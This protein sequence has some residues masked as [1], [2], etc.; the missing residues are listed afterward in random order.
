MPADKNFFE[1]SKQQSVIKTAIV[2][3]Y[4][5]A[6]AKVIMPAAKK[7][8]GRIA[9]IDVF[10]GPGRYGDGTK[11]TPLLILEQAIADSDMREMLVTLL[12]DGDPENVASLAAEIAAL[13]DIG[14]LRHQPQITANIVND[15][16]ARRFEERR[17]VPTLLFIDPWGYKGLSLRLIEAVLKDWGCDCIFFFNYNRISMGLPNEVVAPHLDALFG[18]TRADDLRRRLESL[19]GEDRELAIVEELSRALHDKGGRYVLPFRFRN[20]AG[21]LLDHEGDH[22]QPKLDRGSGCS[23][24]RVQSGG[25]TVP[26]ALRALAA[27]RP[28]RRTPSRGVPRADA[29]NEG[30]LREASYG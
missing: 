21:S 11:S 10:A 19:S 8:G 7:G 1:E 9:Y 15:D 12:N 16:L 6:W 4:F 3:K 25:R 14:K 18:K 20:E 5:W 2:S 23:L 30:G 27:S 29:G 28:A 26:D 17:L 13:P 24:V 22:G